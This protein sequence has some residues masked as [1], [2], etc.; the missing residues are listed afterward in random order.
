[1]GKT[2]ISP[3]FSDFFDTVEHTDIVEYFLLIVCACGAGFVQ[4]TV[5]FGFGIFLI[6]LLFLLGV[7]GRDYK[8]IVSLSSMMAA[9]LSL[10]TVWDLRKSLDWRFIWPLLIVFLPTSTFFSY[11]M[12]GTDASWLKIILGIT[13]ILLSIYFT[14]FKKDGIKIK[15]NWFNTISLGSLSGFMGGLFSMQGPPVVYYY[16][17]TQKTKEEYMAQTQCFFLL[18]NLWMTILRAGEGIITA[19]VGKSYLIAIA[20]CLAGMWIGARV[21]NKMNNGLL[22]KMIYIFLAYS[23][24]SMI[25]GQ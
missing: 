6:P 22:L 1:M 20:G 17:S 15:P 21:Y 10:I 25:I 12:F 18:G 3:S 14:F 16:L 23:G 4:R 5:G 19:E 2:A 7:M 13:L 24:V 9:T 8:S 11:V